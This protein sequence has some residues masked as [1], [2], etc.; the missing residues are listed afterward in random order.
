[1]SLV[2]RGRTWH[3]HFVVNGQR[4]RQ[5]LG[6]TDWREAQAKEKDLIADA[7]EGKL[8]QS[9]VISCLVACFPIEESQQP[10]CPHSRHRRR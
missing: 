3:C 8:S 4:F 1:M 6:T 2:K 9:A 7:R 5:S 10:T